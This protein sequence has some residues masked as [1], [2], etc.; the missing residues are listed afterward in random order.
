M[1]RK[2]NRRVWYIHHAESESLYKTYDRHFTHLAEKEQA[3]I[4]NRTTYEIWM[5]KYGQ[6]KEAVFEETPRGKELIFD[7]D[8]PF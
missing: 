1:R 4:I 6:I 7:D 2:G 5:K 3:D 8:Y